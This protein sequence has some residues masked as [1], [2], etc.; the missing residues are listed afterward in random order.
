MKLELDEFMA[1]PDCQ[2][3]LADAVDD[4]SNRTLSVSIDSRTIAAG[5]IYIAIEGEVHDGHDFVED[6]FSKKAAAALVSVSF[7]D[8]LDP[9]QSHGPLFVVPDT[10]AALQHLACSHRMKYD[11][12]VLALTG[13]N[14]KTTTKEMIAA[15]LSAKGNVC[16]TDGNLNNHIGL[17]LTMLK[18]EAR[19]DFVVAEMGTNHFGEIASLCQIAQPGYGV[20]TNIGHGHTEFLQD[21]EGVARAKM[22]L[23]DYVRADGL[24]FAN[25]DDPL[26]RQRTET[27]SNCLRYGFGEDSDVTAIQL[28]SDAA[29]YPRMQ[30][31]KVTIKPNLTGRHNLANALAAVAVG[32]HFGVDLNSLKRALETLALPAKRLQLLKRDRYTIL[33]DTYNANP[34]STLAALATLRDLPTSGKRVFVMGDMLELGPQA[35]FEHAAIG[36]AL[37]NYDISLF[38]GLGP[39]TVDVINACTAEQSDIVAHHFDDKAALLTSLTAALAP[40]DLVL[41]KGSRG[42]KMEEIVQAL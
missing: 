4:L 38:Y 6:A 17:P 40:D 28:S 25:V 27:C 41:I 26:I 13:T 29:G 32:S 21:V 19:H 10:L 34:E 1:I 42:M 24:F 22:E 16:K 39:A 8:S 31:E 9:D 2:S 7:F 5:E 33:D 37:A 12:P 35:A 14:G 20:V 11:I 23:F 3:H 18:V 15:V 36:K 30:I